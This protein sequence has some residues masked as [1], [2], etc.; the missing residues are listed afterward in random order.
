MKTFKEFRQDVIEESFDV[1]SYIKTSSSDSV[2]YGKVVEI[3]KNGGMKA[4][5]FTSFDGSFAGSAKIAS[6]KNW[7]PA[8]K[9]IKKEE[10]PAKILAKIE[11]KFDE[12]S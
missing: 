3:Q 6:T 4:V 8:P 12:M 7:Y 11:K 5:V 1:G 10:I 2:T 9:M